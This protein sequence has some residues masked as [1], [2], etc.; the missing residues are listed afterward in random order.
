MSRDPFPQTSWSLVSRLLRGGSPLSPE[1]R[2]ALAALYEAYRF[3]VYAYIRRRS[4]SAEDAWD[5]TQGF[6]ARQVEKNDLAGLDRARGP[7]FRAWMLSCVQHYLANVHRDEIAAKRCP[8]TPIG[9]LDA[10]AAEGLYQADPGHRSTPEALYARAFALR[11]LARVI[12]QLAALYAGGTTPLFEA[13]KGTLS[14]GASRRPYAAIGADLGMTEGAVKQAAFQ[15]RE[16]YKELL[17]REVASLLERPDEARV[18][19]EIRQLLASLDDD[20]A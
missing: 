1:G 5:R 2:E 12:E 17:Y 11:L 15:L 16:R 20:P 4:S 19:E 9:S 14:G 13:L 8:G 3:P 6:F 18:R 7:R 10:M